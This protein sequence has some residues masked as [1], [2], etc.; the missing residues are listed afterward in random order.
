MALKMTVEN[1]EE[2]K[3]KKTFSKYEIQNAMQTIMDAEDI[4]ENKALMKEVKKNLDKANKKISS[5]QDIRNAAGKMEQ[6]AEDPNEKDETP[7]DMAEKEDKESRVKNSS[8][9]TLTGKTMK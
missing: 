4:L 3:G 1:E 2:N 8:N 5:I 9:P 7:D 6:F